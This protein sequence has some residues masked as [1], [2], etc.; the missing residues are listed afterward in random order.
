MGKRECLLKVVCLGFFQ[1]MTMINRMKYFLN[2][3]P[4]GLINWVIIISHLILI[5]P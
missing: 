3:L 2:C 5:Q 1:N 4:G